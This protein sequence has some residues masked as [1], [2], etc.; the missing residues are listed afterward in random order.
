MWW[1]ET[2]DDPDF[3]THT[4]HQGP[5]RAPEKDLD[6]SKTP[7][8]R[9]S[10]KE[11][12]KSRLVLLQLKLLAFDSA[13]WNRLRDD[14]QW[15]LDND[16]GFMGQGPYA[17]F[18]FTAVFNY[19]NQTTSYGAHLALRCRTSHQNKP[20]PDPHTEWTHVAPS[21]DVTYSGDPLLEAVA[22]DAWGKEWKEEYELAQ[23]RN[24]RGVDFLNGNKE[25]TPSKLFVATALQVYSK[26]FLE[27]RT[28][29][30]GTHAPSNEQ[31]GS[32]LGRRTSQEG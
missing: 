10:L 28:P 6:N 21:A 32:Q 31:A 13:Y 14:I 8:T 29:I 22:K 30:H 27:S 23:K 9:G 3:V 20:N 7:T 18:A 2:Q 19:N 16:T 25:C 11:F 26:N 5:Y 17:Q 12:V 1:G 4:G 15:W 24:Q